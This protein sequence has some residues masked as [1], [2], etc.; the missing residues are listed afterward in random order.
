MNNL[1]SASADEPGSC[2]YFVTESSSDAGLVIDHANEGYYCPSTRP[3][4]H[5]VGE[6]EQ[7]TVDA[8][9]FMDEP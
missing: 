3:S 7:F 5:P 6:N 2:T 8:S 9:P 1:E 4:P